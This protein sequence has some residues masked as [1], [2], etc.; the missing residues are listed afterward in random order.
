M[1]WR[2]QGITGSNNIPLG[3]RRRFGGDNA[4][5]GGYNPAA[6]AEGLSELKRGRSPQRGKSQFPSRLWSHAEYPAIDP[7]GPRQRKK[8]NR[9]GDASENKAAGLMGL[10]TAIYSAMTTEQLDAYTLH[11]RIEEITQKLKINDV[12]PADGDRSPSPP[13]QYDNFGRRVNTRE[14]RYRKRL[15]DERHKL[16]EKAMKTLPNYHPPADYRRPTKTQEKVY[17]PVN[18][19]P[20]INFSMAL[21]PLT[22]LSWFSSFPAFVLTA[23]S[24][25]CLLMRIQWHLQYSH[26]TNPTRPCYSYQS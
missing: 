25:Y 22:F 12:V 20:E 7:D 4:D 11:L 2:N 23:C 14:F 17:V 21:T 15:E 5:D 16:V 3:N 10:P 26:V 6:P 8:R 1:S 18:D 19:Y 24:G 13:P 9:W